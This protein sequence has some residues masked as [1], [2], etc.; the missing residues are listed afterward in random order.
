MKNKIFSIFAIA[1]LAIA[2]ASCSDDPEY[3]LNGDNATGQVDLSGMGV[4]V[5]PDEITLSRADEIDVNPFLIKITDAGGNIVYQSTYAEMK[6][7][8]TLP[9]GENY[10]VSAE[11]REVEN[12][13]WSAPYYLGTQT[14]SIT[15]NE[16]TEVGKIECKF[17]NIRVSVRYTDELKALMANDVTVT[18][19]CSETGNALE[20][21]ATE[22]RSGYF[23]ALDGSTT[24]G[25]VFSGTVNGSHITVTKALNDVKAGQHRI[26]TF[27]V[28]QGNTDVPD[29]YGN[30]NLNGESSEGTR[31]GDGL[32]LDINITNVDVDGNVTTDEEGDS[33][34]ERPGHEEGGGDV[35]GGDDPKP[36]ITITPSADLSFTTPM[37][38]RE[39]MD[40]NIKIHVDSPNTI[41]HLYVE[42]KTDNAEFSGV[43]TEM[44]IPLTFDLANITDENELKAFKDSL[45]F[46]VN[47]E[48]KGQTDVPFDITDFIPLLNIYSPATNQFILKVVDAQ[49]NTRTETLTFVAK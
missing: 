18:V 13:A 21:S 43:L 31:I 23:K 1:G 6:E 11:S 15:E 30:V 29:E 35:G 32:Y 5:N 38:P 17:A 25:A 37:T 47:D 33:G 19:R 48:V 42:I 22:T 26:I 24:L 46:P 7:I 36:A 44:H 9:V 2:T 8:V 12:A 41:Q 40:G 27:G 49:G 16:I 14:F 4:E 45:H 34:A 10:S 28:K 20:Y 39:G 3:N